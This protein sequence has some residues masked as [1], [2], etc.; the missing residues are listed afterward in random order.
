MVDRSEAWLHTFGDEAY[1]AD[2]LAGYRDG[3]AALLR[4]LNRALAA[5]WDVIATLDDG[6][7]IG[8]GS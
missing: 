1:D 6:V 7:L 2:T 3:V 5:G 8:P 4:T